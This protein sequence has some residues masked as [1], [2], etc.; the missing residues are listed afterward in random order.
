M[1]TD[2]IARA[3][4]KR[5]ESAAIAVAAAISEEN[6]LVEYTGTIEPN[7][8]YKYTADADFSLVLPTISSTNEDIQFI[9]YLTCEQDIDITL[10]ED[11][12]IV[13]DIDTKQ[14]LHK[15]IGTWLV[16]PAAWAIGGIN[17]EAI[18]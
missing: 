12:Y 18:E 6:T 16:D 17:Y 14:G 15:I 11:I 3:M 5:A 4:A 1:V 10:P 8:K 13:G 7:K 9:M 2:I